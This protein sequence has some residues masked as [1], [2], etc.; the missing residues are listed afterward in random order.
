MQVWN[1]SKGVS[2]QVG[3]VTLK[4]GEGPLDVPIHIRAEIAPL[5]RSGILSETNPSPPPK[6]ETVVKK[7]LPEEPPKAEP[8]KVESTEVAEP[9][10][11]RL[12]SKSRG[13]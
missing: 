8:P 4:P 12:G 7:P 3:D 11:P 6:K 10:A 13:E 9:K 5:I 1:I 2:A